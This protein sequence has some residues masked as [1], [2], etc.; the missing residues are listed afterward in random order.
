MIK[1]VGR[2]SPMTPRA[3]S[4]A[5]AGGDT[6]QRGLPGS[7][8]Q[9]CAKPMNESSTCSEV[10][11]AICAFVNHHCSSR[12]RSRSKP[13]L[14]GASIMRLSRLARSDSCMSSSRSKRR[15]RIAD[16][17]A[18]EFR[19]RCAFIEGDKLDFR[20][21]RGH[22]LGFDFADDPGK[23]GF[24]PRRLKGAQRRQR[25]AGIADCRETQQAHMLERRFKVQGTQEIAYPKRDALKGRAQ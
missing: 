18:P 22:Q 14:M 17:H 25:V 9:A 21:Q 3:Y 8:P 15:P 16:A 20:N 12:A 13:S 5:S 6:S 4:S 7:M 10:A 24:R 11:A 23:A 2:S 19:E 1:R